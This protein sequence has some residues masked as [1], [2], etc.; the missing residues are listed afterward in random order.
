MLGVEGAHGYY[1]ARSGLPFDRSVSD[2]AY[3]YW[4]AQIGGSAPLDIDA[5]ELAFLQANTTAQFDSIGA[6]RKAYF[7]QLTGLTGDVSYLARQAYEGV[8]VSPVS[9]RLTRLELTAA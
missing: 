1:A 7:A 8:S 9:A 5:R 6:A 4:G 3:A 2:H